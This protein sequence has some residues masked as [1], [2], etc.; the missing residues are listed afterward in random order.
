MSGRGVTRRQFL[1]A[2][3]GGAGVAAVSSLARAG[4]ALAN[5]GRRRL[6]VGVLVP[7]GGDEAGMAASLLDG[8]RLGFGEDVDARIEAA[9]VLLGVH[10]ARARAEEMLDAGARVVI[11]GVSAPVALRLAGMFEE[12]GA[13]LVAANAG[14]HV[15]RPRERRASVTHVSLQQWQA[16]YALGR[17]AA[18]K[19]G[20][21]GL[22]AAPIS[23]SGYDTVYA[24]RRGFESAGGTV[25]G[26]MV[27]HAQE[28]GPSE[29]DVMAAVAEAGADVLLGL[30]SGSWGADL[31]RAHAAAGRPVPL[32]GTGFLAQERSL[33]LQGH[34]ANGLRTVA[35]WSPALRTD[36]NR[37]FLRAFRQATGRQADAYAV[38]GHDAARIIAEG[39]TRRGKRDRAVVA[40]PRGPLRVSR[41][42]IVLGPLY[43]RRVRSGSGGLEHA[44]VRRLKA[45]TAFPRPLSDLGRA[46]A[47]GYLNE[48]LCA[49]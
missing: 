2:A 43:L 15:V 34:A 25:V 10:G 11:A 19:V 47:S 49:T 18:A 7:T 48:Y 24:L 46:P 22:I 23:D 12:R 14:A 45:P 1:R 32:V 13:R 37:G 27:T 36:E 35:S 29:H 40:S 6:H 5:G 20:R 44:V 39:A 26:T 4:D 28:S 3:G 30:H 9:E 33:R 16:A 38:L 31:I 17:W 21:R 8:V 41:T 42:G